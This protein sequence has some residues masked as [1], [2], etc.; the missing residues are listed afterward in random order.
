MLLILGLISGLWQDIK[1]NWQ[2][3]PWFQNILITPIFLYYALQYSRTNP[4]QPVISVLTIMLTVRLSGEKTVR[5]SKQIYA[6]SIFCLASSSL[7]DLSPVFLLYLGLLLFMVAIALILLTFQSQD[8]GMLVTKL[9]LKRILIFG[10]MIPVISVPLILFFFPIMPRTQLPLWNFLNP[11]PSGTSG[12]SEIVEPGSKSNVSASH[13]LVF[14]AE[15][16]RQED[17]K[18]YWR[19]TVFNFTD[20][21]K[22]TR[23]LQI[24]PENI[25]SNKSTV[26]QL[27]FPE[28]SAVRTLFSLDR[29]VT[30]SLQRIKL[31][32]DGVF[33]LS[34]VGGRRINYSAESNNGGNVTQLNNINRRFYLQLPEQFP[35]RLKEL[36]S[37]LIR[38]GNSDRKRVEYLE[39]FYRLSH[40]RYS[41]NNLPIGD[42]VLDRFLFEIKQGNC[43]YFASSFALILRSAGIPCRLVGGFFGGEYNKLGGY[44]LVSE[45]KAHVWVEAFI[46][47]EGWIRIDPSSFAENS[48]EVWSKKGS[49]N[50]VF[51]L[52]LAID[53]FNHIWN[54]SV[55]SY[56]LEQQISFASQLGSS[57]RGIQPLK[58]IWNVIPYIV[59]CLLITSI[60]FISK[61][62]SLFNSREQRILNRFLKLIK[63]KFNISTVESGCGLFEVTSV[64]NCSK[65]SNFV[66]IYAAAIYHDRR[67]TDKEYEKLMKIL[68]DMQS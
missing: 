37:R 5:H 11:L 3:K 68:K 8:A 34:R 64:A 29:P 46:E 2:L 7:Y 58:R 40:L 63:L 16:P 1:G 39:N 66:G 17:S 28:P 62:M 6:L 60:Y 38:F 67:L 45:D 9:D 26:N 30:I 49:K 13:S 24:P 55:I 59:G 53:S 23:T 33:E 51:R 56:D 44:Y 65:V 43:E 12:Y 25:Y 15:M 22:W 61:R 31:S 47:G 35:T 20:G 32:P 42:R 50:L 57:F 4:I 27:I 52:T 54:R 48:G 18:L 21:I 10:I 41:T 19:G 36:S 14:R